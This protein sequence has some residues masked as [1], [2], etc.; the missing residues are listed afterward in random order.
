MVD[1]LP[2]PQLV[3]ERRISNEPST[4]LASGSSFNGKHIP[5]FDVALLPL[6][7][8][9]PQKTNECPLKI[10]GWLVQMYFLLKVRP[11][12]KGTC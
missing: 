8:D 12:K 7:S 5:W 11:F 2:V 4:V 1:Q 10:N 3:S 9:T 6:I